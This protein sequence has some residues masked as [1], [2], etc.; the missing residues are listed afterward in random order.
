MDVGPT[1]HAGGTHAGLAG[2]VIKR[3]PV[4][5][6]LLVQPGAVDD[7]AS[8]PPFPEAYAVL[9]GEA[10]D[11][12]RASAHTAAY[13]VQ[14][15]PLIEVQLGEFVLGQR[16]PR[17]R[18]HLSA[19]SEVS[20]GGV[21]FQKVPEGVDCGAELFGRSLECCL[22][23]ADAL[24]NFRDFHVTQVRARQFQAGQQRDGW[25]PAHWFVMDLVVMQESACRVVESGDELGVR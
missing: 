16:H 4:D 25:V 18:S 22:A 19:S 15:Q 17:G 14:A 12:L 13:L 11:G 24:V 8:T 20:G 7:G 1:V 2:Q 10:R 3:A 5:E 21:F 9:V 6:V 23:L